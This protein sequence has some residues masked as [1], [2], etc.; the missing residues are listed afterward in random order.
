MVDEH[1]F[2]FA[3]TTAEEFMKLYMFLGWAFNCHK[4]WWRRRRRTV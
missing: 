2:F 1:V 4:N 3:V